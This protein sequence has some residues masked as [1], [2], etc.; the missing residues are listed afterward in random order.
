MGNEDGGSGQ[1]FLKSNGVNLGKGPGK[2]RAYSSE[3]RKR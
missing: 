2:E 1:I 3:A